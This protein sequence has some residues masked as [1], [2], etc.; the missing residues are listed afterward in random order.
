MSHQ[1]AQSGGENGDSHMRNLYD[2]GHQ[3]SAQFGLHLALGYRYGRFTE[4]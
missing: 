4:D 2:V 1:G 3:C